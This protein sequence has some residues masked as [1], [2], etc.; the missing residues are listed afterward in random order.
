MPS[1][2][3]VDLFPDQ[4]AARVV[5]LHPLDPAGEDRWSLDLELLQ[6]RTAVEEVSPL[7]LALKT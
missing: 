1:R 4:H 2:L 7:R 5:K 6:R 3:V